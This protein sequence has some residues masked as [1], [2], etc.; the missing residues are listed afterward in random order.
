[1]RFTAFLVAVGAMVAG[2]PAFAA[3]VSLSFQNAGTTAMTVSRVNTCG[4]LA[5]TPTT[6]NIGTTSAVSSTDCGSAASAA[7]VTY[8][9]GTKQCIFRISTIFT[10]GNPILG[11]SGYWTPNANTEASGGATC[12]V[13]SQDV[14]GVFTTGAFKAVFSMR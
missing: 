5:P 7:N 13:V 14:S 2:A 8:R 3:P 12:R 6:V 4:V 11:T 10:P 1:M 9:M